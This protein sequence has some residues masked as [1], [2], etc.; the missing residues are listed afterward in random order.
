M[1]NK[2]RSL[3]N[4]EFGRLQPFPQRKAKAQQSSSPVRKRKRLAKLRHKRGPAEE[5]A[6]DQVSPLLFDS[7]ADDDADDS[8]SERKDNADEEA[9]E[10]EVVVVR[11]A[12]PSQRREEGARLHSV[13]AE[14]CFNAGL[15]DY[16][17]SANGGGKNAVFINTL[18]RKVFDLVHFTKFKLD[19]TGFS[20]DNAD[21]IQEAWSIVSAIAANEVTKISQ[22]LDDLRARYKRQ[23]L[24]LRF[25]VTLYK[26]FYGWFGGWFADGMQNYPIGAQDKAKLDTTLRHLSSY[27]HKAGKKT[28]QEDTQSIEEM[29]A[30]RTWPKNGFQDLKA[31]LGPHI[32]RILAMEPD[33]IVTNDTDYSYFM[34]IM[35]ASFYSFGVQG[36]AGGVKSM[37]LSQAMDLIET[38]MC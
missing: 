6:D 12:P 35:I 17:S 25:Y 19:G 13:F 3:L 8:E 16:L 24:T 11:P 22:H 15:V 18:V 5:T 31:A 10:K 37:L 26:E 33:S 9:D 29:I 20:D 4:H 27:Y 2:P 38:G 34:K 30:K 1:S 23:P 32:E 14:A 36:R 7:D 21:F 28:M